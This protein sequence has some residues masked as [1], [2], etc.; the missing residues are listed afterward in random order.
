MHVLLISSNSKMMNKIIFS[1]T[2]VGMHS[3]SYTVVCH[4]LGLF[5]KLSSQFNL[6]TINKWENTYIS[7]E[8]GK[9]LININRYNSWRYI[10]HPQIWERCRIKLLS[11]RIDILVQKDDLHKK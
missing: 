11:S 1:Y 7:L 5:L 8:I 4:T 3:V 10:E 9:L 2:M 6:E